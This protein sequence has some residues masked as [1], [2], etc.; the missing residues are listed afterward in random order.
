MLLTIMNKRLRKYLEFRFLMH[1]FNRYRH[2]MNEWI[3]NVTPEQCQYFEKEMINL[4]NNGI[5]T[6]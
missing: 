1:C 5:Y 6:E 4:I 3:D 2:Y